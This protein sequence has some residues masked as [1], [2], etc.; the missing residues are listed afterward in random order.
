ML[1]ILLLALLQAP[2]PLP[3]L[4]AKDLQVVRG[5]LAPTWPDPACSPGRDLMDQVRRTARH[6]PSIPAL[7]LPK[8]SVRVKDA[9]PDVSGWRAYHLDVPPSGKV[10]LKI[11]EGR[12]A[13][14]RVQAV[15]R[16]GRLEEGMLQNLIANGEPMATYN[17]PSATETKEVWF[18]VDTTDKNMTGE[19]FEVEVIRK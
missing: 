15:N 12:K 7:A 5:P 13:W 18:V 9:I 6:G 14:Y 11:V 17:N 19:A 1:P 4:E 3:L 8:E 2:A 16:W 10:Q